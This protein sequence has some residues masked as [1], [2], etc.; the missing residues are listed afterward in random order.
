MIQLYRV[1]QHKIEWNPVHKTTKDLSYTVC[2]R[3]WTVRFA[4]RLT[5]M[6]NEI[7]KICSDDLFCVECEPSVF[8]A[9]STAD[10][11][12]LNSNPMDRFY[13]VHTQAAL[14][15]RIRVA[16]DYIPRS[17]HSVC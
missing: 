5:Q 11:I 13:F 12:V 17:H 3:V 2:E 16:T 14:A 9:Y 4:I 15:N 8:D 6:Y 10:G 1:Q 7:G